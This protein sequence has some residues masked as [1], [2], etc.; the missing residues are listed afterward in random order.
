MEG[1]KRVK[2][3]KK[4]ATSLRAVV[5]TPNLTNTFSSPIL[6]AV[7]RKLPFSISLFSSHYISDPKILTSL[8]LQ[9]RRSL[10]PYHSRRRGFAVARGDSENGA[11]PIRHYDFRR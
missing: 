7:Y 10:T 11:E 5:S 1:T 3:I 8:S 6:H 9:H 4:V 2:T